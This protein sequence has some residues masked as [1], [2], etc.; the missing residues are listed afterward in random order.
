MI[1][2]LLIWGVGLPL[3]AGGGV[4]LAGRPWRRGAGEGEEPAGRLSFGALALG[5]AYAVGHLGRSGG[6]GLGV[7]GGLLTIALAGLAAALLL[8]A[9]RLPPMVGWTLRLGVS[10]TAAVVLLQP[11]AVPQQWSGPEL[12]LRLGLVAGATLVAWLALERVVDRV[13][14]AGPPLAVAALAAGSSAVVVMGGLA[15]AA[16]LMAPLPAVLG[17]AFVLALRWPRSR[18]L[19][20]AAPL[21]ALTLVGHWAAAVFYGE[22]PLSALV[23]LALAPVAL[24]LVRLPRLARIGRVALLAAHLALVTVPLGGALVRAGISYFSVSAPAPAGPDGTAGP[25][26]SSDDDYGYGYGYE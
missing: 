14:G 8:G 25:A 9:V 3:L 19:N 12:A 21:L 20:G 1:E 6:P 16:Q 4:L 7:E 22:L 24:L 10:L 18:L 5:V 23:L 15:S 26:S 17:L 13:D 11:L 2:T